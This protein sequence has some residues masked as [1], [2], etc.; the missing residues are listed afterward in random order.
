[1]GSTNKKKKENTPLERFFP[2]IVGI[3]A[4]TTNCLIAYPDTITKR[5]ECIRNEDGFETTPSVV[6]IRPDQE[7]D[8]GRTAKGEALLYP[9]RTKALYKREIGRAKVSIT[10]DHIDYSPQQMTALVLGRLKKD[11]E[12]ELREEVLDAVITVP[13]YFDSNQRKA[14]EEAGRMAGYNVRDILDEPV[15]VVYNADSLDALQGCNLVVDVGG[16]TSDLVVVC[17][18]ENTIEEK[19]ID[20]DTMLGGSDWDR[21]FVEYIRREKLKGKTLDK[22]GEGELLL[23]A[24][25]AKKKLS[26]KEETWFT[27]NTNTGREKVTVTRDEFE[28]CTVEWLLKLR[29]IVNRV[30]DTMKNRGMAGLNSVI[31][32]GGSTRM[33]Q[34][35]RMIE[36]CFPGIRIIARDLDTAVAKGA[37]MYAK[38]LVLQNNRKLVRDFAADPV[39]ED[40]FV[41]DEGQNT[42]KKLLRVSSR[43]YGVAAYVDEERKVCNILYRNNTLPIAETEDIFYTRYA[44]Q[45]EVGIDVYE[46]RLD[47]PY[48]EVRDCTLVGNCKLKIC[49]DLPKGSPLTIGLALE[50]DGTLHVRGYEA[51]GRTEVTAVMQTKA[52]L[53]EN[54]FE[55]QKNVVEGL[56]LVL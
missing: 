47:E 22:E 12:E 27:V 52:L 32:A 8:I 16:G 35:M 54:E 38:D 45:K 20:G 43:T 30:D 23:N 39:K 19:L 7:I 37:A 6:C 36:G 21:S 3:D 28:T 33:P 48:V 41:N 11:A 49:G 24:E 2:K 5:G 29:D 14:T 53:D 9:D 55:I 40:P 15:A 42:G 44:N 26:E 34:I 51:T 13:A 46:S 50:E 4:G 56:L 1:M 10:V 18:T 31:L 25:E 17:V